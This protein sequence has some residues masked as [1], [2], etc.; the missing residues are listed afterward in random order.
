MSE[1]GR[2]DLYR[3]AEKFAAAMKRRDG[4]TAKQLADA[5]ARVFRDVQGHFDALSQQ[6]MTMIAADIVFTIDR[7][8]RLDRY[9]GL[10]RV[11]SEKLDEFAGYAPGV[12][13]GAQQ[14]A[15]ERATAE[16]ERLF[17]LAA[18]RSARVTYPKAVGRGKLPKGFRPGVFQSAFNRVPVEALDQFV[19]TLGD[20]TPLR[21][22][23]LGGGTT[24]DA[25]PLSDEVIDRVKRN[26]G[27]ALTAGWSP[28]K[29]ARLFADA[30]GVGLTR[31][32]RIARTETL[33]SYREASRANYA[34]NGLEEWEWLATL[35]DRACL[36]CIALD[37]QEFAID[38]PMQAHVNC[39]CT[40][41]PVLPF[42]I[43]RT[44]RQGWPKKSIVEGTGTDW[45]GSLPPAQQ[46]LVMGPSK[47][48]A[49]AA[50]EVTLQDFVGLSHSRRKTFGTQF[51]ENSLRAAKNGGWSG[52]KAAPKTLGGPGEPKQDTIVP[53]L[54]SRKQYSDWLLG[55][56][57]VSSDFAG[58]EV[59]LVRELV[60]EVTWH[61]DRFPDTQDLVTFVG[62]F[63]GRNIQIKNHFR[64]EVERLVREQVLRNPEYKNYTEK[65]IRR[66]VNA[67]LKNYVKKNY[68]NVMALAY[69]DIE[70]QLET[71]DMDRFTGIAVNETFN[72]YSDSLYGVKNQFHPEGTGN[73]KAVI[74]HEMG[75]QVDY[76]YGIGARQTGEDIPRNL[77]HAIRVAERMDGGVVGSLSK[78]ATTDLDKGKTTE[79]VAE[80]WS[81]FLNNPTPRRPAQLVGEIIGELMEEGWT[82]PVTE[83]GPL[84]AYEAQKKEDMD[85]AG[86]AL[87]ELWKKLGVIPR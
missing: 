49:F 46:A 36:A 19:G 86:A 3:E 35:D 31:A 83:K 61:F 77:A 42:A 84:T 10:L 50:G 8:R 82:L 2:G 57:G 47:Y 69:S 56:F 21:D 12:I 30:M 9:A 67:N 16:S 41:V 78:Y 5:Y 34:A 64:P 79:F 37:G 33:R 55:Q 40:M 62:T 85:A 59:D 26:L 65:D 43:P 27:E 4:A 18:A 14:A 15:V 70:G 6:L 81:E 13:A 60:E 76:A 75:H 74:D 23:F 73:F 52:W 53:D 1:I 22:Y 68:E 32:L 72:Y 66:S 24:E 38:Q 80:A 87:D 45:F 11:V 7:V 44:R 58:L 54:K 20:G 29:A 17:G 51:V 39:R 25:P 63:K 48:E 71:G 28:K